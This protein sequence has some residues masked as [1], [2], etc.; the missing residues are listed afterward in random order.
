MSY[1]KVGIFTGLC[2]LGALDTF[3]A[4]VTLMYLNRDSLDVTEMVT[5]SDPVVQ[6]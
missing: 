3:F 5:S 1:K 4:A 2:H 6:V